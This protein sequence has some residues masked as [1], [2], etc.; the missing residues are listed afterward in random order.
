MIGPMPDGWGKLTTIQ[1]K[2]ALET[3]KEKRW[4]VWSVLDLG[5]P[6]DHEILKQW[7]DEEASDTGFWRWVVLAIVVGMA[8]HSL[9]ARCYW[10][11]PRHRSQESCLP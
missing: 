9:E 7:K 1:K 3:A 10:F 5:V 8:I 6:E 2:W 4:Q 11:S